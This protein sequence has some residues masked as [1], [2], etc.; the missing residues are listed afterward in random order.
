MLRNLF[1]LIVFMGLGLTTYVIYSSQRTFQATFKN[2]DGLPK[3]APVT[4]LGVRVGEVIRTKPFKNGILV[5]IRITKKSFKTPEPGSQL[6]ITS[7]RPGQGRVIEVIPPKEKI[8]ERNAWVIQEPI[9]NQSWLYASLD[10]LDGIER[11]SRDVIV[12][13]TPENF[14][15]TRSA[16]KI[17]STSLNQTASHLSNYQESLLILKDNLSEKA[18]EGS[19]VVNKANITLSMLSKSLNIDS[20]GVKNSFSEFTDDLSNVSVSVG[21]STLPGKLKFFK[22]SI[23]DYLTDVNSSLIQ[24]GKNIDNPLYKEKY[25]EF[26][27]G[28]QKLNTLIAKHDVSKVLSFKEK[29]HKASEATARTSELTKQ[30]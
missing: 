18:D 8:D 6:T 17:A 13:V 10:I 4:A 19:R 16:L 12:H 20:T 3:G 15:K 2:V 5:T 29:V 21:N 22:S 26:K 24:D 27:S 14:T 30:N 25:F 28:I 11:F 23:Q 7:F 1:A 9:T